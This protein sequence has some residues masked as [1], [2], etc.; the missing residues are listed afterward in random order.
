ME[1]RKVSKYVVGFTIHSGKAFVTPNQAPIDPLVVVRC[2]GREFRTKVKYKK[3]AV[4]QWDE[5]F[6]WNDLILTDA[7]WETSYISF[8]VQSANSL[9]KNDVIGQC[10]IQLKVLRN[11]KNHFLK[12]HFTITDLNDTFPK[13]LLYLTVYACGPK[14]TPPTTDILELIDT[15]QDDEI[16]SE[17]VDFTSQIV[18]ITRKDSQMMVL[19]KELQMY[20]L[21]ISIYRVEDLLYKRGLRDPFVTVEFSG[22][23]MQ[24]TIARGVL[25]H[26]FNECF[27]LPVV[28]PVVEDNI[29]I[30]LWDNSYNPPKI[31][32]QG[33]FSFAK[34]RIAP[35]PPRWYNFYGNSQSEFFE[36]QNSEDQGSYFTE[37]FESNADTY[38]G[39]LLVSIKTELLRSKNQL[40]PAQLMAAQPI[41]DLYSIQC[42]IVA[43]VYSLKGT[44]GDKA[45]VEVSIGPVKQRSEW[46]E[47]DYNV[48]SEP[49]S[50]VRGIE[51]FETKNQHQ[52]DNF[53]FG[54][55]QGRIPEIE[56]EYSSKEE[57][58]W[59]IIISVYTSEK[60][61]IKDSNWA[62]LIGKK[63]TDM[64]KTKRVAYNR[65]KLMDI[66]DYIE[67]NPTI[68]VWIPL[69]QTR[70]GWI[71]MVNEKQVEINNHFKHTFE[72][73]KD[74]IENNVQ[75]LNIDLYNIGSSAI[76]IS[77]GK[78]LG[79]VLRRSKRHTM[80]DIEYE[81]RCY[82]YA[83]RNL[84]EDYS[85]GLTNPY[86][87][88]SCSGVYTTSSVKSETSNPSF[89]ECLILRHTVATDSMTSKPTVA[90]ITI[91]V[92]SR[93]SWGKRY[94]GSCTCIYDRLRGRLRNNEVIDIL[95]PCWVKLKGGKNFHT[96]VGDILLCFDIVKLKDAKLIPPQPL[97]PKLKKVQLIFT[98]T[99]L[100]DLFLI[101][102]ANIEETKQKKFSLSKDMNFQNQGIIGSE[103]E[104]I[105]MI[106]SNNDDFYLQYNEKNNLIS[107]SINQPI[108]ELIVSSF[109]KVDASI[110]DE[111]ESTDK[112]NTKDK[113][114]NET[115]SHTSIPE[116]R[117]TIP[118]RSITTVGTSEFANR[119]WQTTAGSNF[120][121]FTNVT[122][123]IYIPI[124]PLY[125]PKVTIRV[126]EAA[127]DESALIGECVL[128][129]VSFLPWIPDVDNAQ[130]YITAKNDYSH[131]IDI[132]TLTNILSKKTEKGD[133]LKQMGLA[134][135][136]L[137]DIEDQQE[138]QQQTTR[139]PFPALQLEEDSKN[140]ELEN[141][142]LNSAG[143]P[144]LLIKSYTLPNVNYPRVSL[145]MFTINTH[146]PYHFVMVAEGEATKSGDKM[147]ILTTLSSGAGGIIVTKQNSK[148]IS[149]KS[150]LDTVM[151]DFLSDISLPLFPL[152]KRSFQGKIRIFGYIRAFILLALP[153]VINKIN[154]GE[155]KSDNMSDNMDQ[156][157]NAETSKKKADE[158]SAAISSNQISR[159]Y[160]L[161]TT[162]FILNP[163]SLYKK[164]KGENVYPNPIKVRLY[165]LAALALVLPKDIDE[166]VRS[167]DRFIPSNIGYSYISKLKSY[168]SID[169]I[170]RTEIRVKSFYISIVYGTKEEN[171]RALA[172]DGPSPLFYICQEYNVSF[173]MESRF[174]IRVWAIQER[175]YPFIASKV[176][177][178]VSSELAKNTNQYSV[179]AEYKID[180]NVSNAE[181]ITRS[182][183]MNRNSSLEQEICQELGPEYDIYI[184]STIL[185]LTDRWQ[186][187]EWQSLMKENNIPIE[188]RPLYC[189]NTSNTNTGILQMWVE[190]MN[191][192]LSSTIQRY[193]LAEPAPTE[194]EIRIVI[195]AGR[196]IKI[197][198]NKD[199]G[200]FAIQVSLDCN[201]YH[202][203]KVKSRQ[204]YSKQQL[205]DVH[206]N[207]RNGEP[208]FNW[209]VVFPYIVTPVS[210]C[211][212]QISL[213][214][215]STLGN[216]D[217]LGEV[218]LDMRKYI[219]NVANTLEMIDS[220]VELPLI[221]TQETD[222][223]Y[224]NPGYVQLTIQILT[225]SEANSKKVGLGRNVPNRLPRLIT[226]FIGR[227]WE[228]FLQTREKQDL[229]KSTWFK[230][231]IICIIAMTILVFVIGAIY[232]A[233]F[234]QTGR[235]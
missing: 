151:E 213:L 96:H 12:R 175:V 90:P 29:L 233:L 85:L 38:L 45:C 219:M 58:V 232:P 132:K 34:V 5:T 164:Y 150:S 127:V 56:I 94:I 30:K 230:I 103:I 215:Y 63:S 121:F 71:Q 8:E 114:G 141:Q 235:V 143:I 157:N 120:E 111:N 82:I 203:N 218:N 60:Q 44:I 73:L 136:A 185:D 130:E 129:L 168:L 101:S 154:Q 186:S 72:D 7:E 110:R 46:V 113:S 59:D 210:G 119:K 209:R 226:P 97:F 228:D 134:S 4:A 128:P 23:R 17:I 124:S 174:E 57:D 76:L 36:T 117:Y 162:K 53:T 217:F 202:G 80:K 87:V 115:L 86:V 105:R 37:I 131:Q 52:M 18:D 102:K 77:I 176:L 27:R 66:P 153:D 183:K 227:K 33:K 78:L 98:S 40:M 48:F 161:E 225:Q 133:T 196:G 11:R 139:Y 212:L 65:I 147:S 204:M 179:D 41:D 88:A 170:L 2:S 31:I 192:S 75:K 138:M 6:A 205:T 84:H 207:C 156:L 194:V 55:T 190:I 68:P 93:H 234:Y 67:N 144:L 149:F 51:L 198:K 109:G 21:H 79:P 95:E 49:K 108:I 89:M 159:C 193:E 229:F 221:N 99:M 104:K 47:R 54:A 145:N 25:G 163:N 135:V 125:D 158:I 178:L 15:D 216:H 50:K 200:D 91:S 211:L 92:F 146:I 173:P 83:C 3:L 81:L 1:R 116:F 180:E 106:M 64:F 32:S 197:P 201:Q 166:I 14:D 43:D 208:V 160:S 42:H 137:A 19:E 195:W 182:S 167:V 61:I 107:E 223:V 199:Y 171:F 231:K 220:D 69:K 191:T 142:G 155:K 181:V 9:W 118:W 177:G 62:S 20:H 222:E 16:D 100:N 172:R 224:R 35:I 24:T 165:I 126:Y 10:S 187:K 169:S 148:I 74:K 22:C 112:Y 189:D 188:Y 13:G 70:E 184:G 152:K 214:N 123:D 39:R 122:L 206:Y 28:L 26:N 140:E